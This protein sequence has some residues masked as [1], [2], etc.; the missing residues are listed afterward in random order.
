MSAYS[1]P[2]IQSAAVSQQISVATAVKAKSVTKQ[3]GE[4]AV[5]LIES[6]K[7]LQDQQNAAAARGG[8]DRLA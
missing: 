6:A 5:A 7:V 1:D 8:V 2:A 3:Q 4:A